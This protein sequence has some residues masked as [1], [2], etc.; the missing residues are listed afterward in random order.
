MYILIGIFA[1]I[2]LLLVG[3]RMLGSHV[4]RLGSRRFRGGIGRAVRLPVVV[5]SLGV[6]LGAVMLSA[7]AVVTICVN[8]VGVGLVKARQIVPLLI[9]SNVGTAAL[10]LV[11]TRDVHLLVA[12]LMAAV[13]VLY[14]FEV[15]RKAQLRSVAGLVL[16]AGLLFFGIDLV[17]EGAQ[18]LHLLPLTQVWIDYA[19]D[20]FVIG[21]IALALLAGIAA[22]MAAG[23]SALVAVVTI[24]LAQAGLLSLEQGMA[25]IYGAG[26]GSA[27]AL[28][29]STGKRNGT[30]RQLAALEI[31]TK[32]SGAVVLVP[33]FAVELRGGVPLVR[34][35][36]QGI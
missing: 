36:V 25:I 30:P 9:W 32:L 29:R 16:G 27:I 12:L 22:A 3:A 11:A 8:A 4:K 2:G 21:F 10:V 26:I 18:S 23:S 17:R 13:A 35:L 31:A 15:D 33:L 1:G 6:V 7:N 24:M 28:W 5:G 19:H 14:Y 20:N 34:A